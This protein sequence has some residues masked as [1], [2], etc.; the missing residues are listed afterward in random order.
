[1]LE[2]IRR[3][4]LVCAIVPMALCVASPQARAQDPAG[5]DVPSFDPTDPAPD[6]TVL[7]RRPDPALPGGEVAIRHGQVDSAGLKL[8][9]GNLSVLQPTVITV[10]SAAGDDVRVD[11]MAD[12]WTD[13]LRSG[14]TG[15]DGA[16]TF[17]LR[18][19]G[20]VNIRVRGPGPT[21]V[22]FGLVAWVG[23][24]VT[25]DLADDVILTPEE[26]RATRASL[27]PASGVASSEGASGRGAS[28]PF[29]VL[30]AFLAGGLLVLATVLL[31]RRNVS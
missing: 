28:V 22:A 12:G 11:L 20:V 8:R 5:E 6:V 2:S 21:P 13:P 29:V 4:W 1:M 14:A 27:E 9:L 3:R 24:E 18:T 23:D 31:V 7:D 19:E 26:F 15:P 17:E 10:L 30:A 25:P 16:V